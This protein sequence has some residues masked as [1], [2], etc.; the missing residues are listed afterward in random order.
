MDAL[1]RRNGPRSELEATAL[2]AVEAEAMRPF[3]VI[4]RDG[5]DSASKYLELKLQVVL[6]R[7]IAMHAR[8][9]EQMLGSQDLTQICLVVHQISRRSTLEGLNCSHK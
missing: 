1:S 9:S 2:S 4:G 7:R 3:G 6:N 8:P 5:R